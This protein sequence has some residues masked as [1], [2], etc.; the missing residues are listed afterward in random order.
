MSTEQFWQR[1]ISRIFGMLALAALLSAYLMVAI[2]LACAAR[3]GVLSDLWAPPSGGNHGPWRHYPPARQFLDP[4]IFFVIA[5]GFLAAMSLGL[6]VR[7]LP[8]LVLLGCS[9]YF[10]IYVAFFAVALD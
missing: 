6:Q 5:A 9:N 2:C 1:R 8:S 10:L 3:D 7:R 4:S